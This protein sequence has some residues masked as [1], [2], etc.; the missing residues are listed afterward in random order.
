MIGIRHRP[1]LPILYNA[2]EKGGAASDQPTVL[3]V[4]PVITA[5]IR[6]IRVASTWL[7]C[8]SATMSSWVDTTAAMSKHRPSFRD[9]PS[10]YMYVRPCE[11]VDPY[12][13]HVAR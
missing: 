13:A 2:V 12:S 11:T 8:Y 5:L 6:S 1:D 3:A 9:E 4:A 7:V 10:N